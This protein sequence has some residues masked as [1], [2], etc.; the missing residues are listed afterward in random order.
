MLY[1]RRRGPRTEKP[2]PGYVRKPKTC[3]LGPLSLRQNW[4]YVAVASPR[5]FVT[6]ISPS[7]VRQREA[8]ALAAELRARS[9]EV[10]ATVSAARRHMD[11]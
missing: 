10:D 7:Q 2:R 8:E 9:A 5:A 1:R 11:S 6:E 4:K 3:E